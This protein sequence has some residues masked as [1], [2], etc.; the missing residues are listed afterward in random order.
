MMPGKLPPPRAQSFVTCR[1]IYEDR[2]SRECILIGP[3]GGI[4]LSSFP[5]SFRFSLYA[6]LCGAHGS[7]ELALQLRDDELEQV[8]GWQWPEPLSHDNPLAP[9]H[10]ILHDL[11]IEFPRPGRY[12]LVLLANGEEVSYRSLEVTH[13][14]KR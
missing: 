4:K 6:D 10:I 8:W 13:C 9:H 3:F 7:F 11:V 5:G 12:D 14:Q 1:T 2:R